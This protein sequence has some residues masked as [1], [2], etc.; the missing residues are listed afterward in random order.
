M[1]LLTVLNFQW[2][3]T[4]VIVRRDCYNS[5]TSSYLWIIPPSC[6]MGFPTF[7]TMI[8]VC[9]RVWALRWRNGVDTVVR[10]DKLWRSCCWFAE[11]IG[12]IVCPS[13]SCATRVVAT[14]VLWI[15]TCSKF[16]LYRLRVRGV[17][18][19]CCCVETQLR[20]AEL[21]ELIARRHQITGTFLTLCVFVD[22]SWRSYAILEELSHQIAERYVIFGSILSTGEIFSI[23]IVSWRVYFWTCKIWSGENPFRDLLWTFTAVSRWVHT[24]FKF[25]NFSMLEL[26]ID[27]GEN[28][29]YNVDMLCVDNC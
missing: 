18:T 11:V 19:R 2:F 24:Q 16:V 15:R 7:K 26:I 20:F 13:L 3:L 6:F 14:N 25:M 8:T 28:F 23:T 9:G 17:L 29:L 12:S 27:V 21:K 22:K 5:G 10:V 4:Y 1:G